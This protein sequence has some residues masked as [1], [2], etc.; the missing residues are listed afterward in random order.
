M[1]NSTATTPAASALS[2]ELADSMS[3]TRAMA[4]VEG[5]ATEPTPDPILQIAFGFM[6]SKVL[7]A[8]LE[9]DVFTQLA[10]G[11]LSYELLAQRTGLHHRA[12]R[13][14]LDTLVAMKLLDRTEGVYSLSLL[15]ARYLDRT[16]PG[17]IGGLLEM[18]DARLYGFWHRLPEALRTGHPQNEIRDGESSFQALY[19]DA[20]RLE[21]F[22][23]AMTGLSLAPAR[24]IAAQFPWNRYRTVLDVGCAEGG[25]L[26]EVAARH[27]HIRG[28][29]YDLPVV[30]P[31]FQ[32]YVHSRRVADRVHFRPGDFFADPGLPSAD[33]IVMGHIL[34][35]WNLGEKRALLEKA[36][37]ALPKGGALIVYESLIDDDR[38]E[39][40]AG[41]LMSLNM[42]IETQ[43]GFDFTGRDCMGWMAEA[44]F[45]ETRVEA[46]A[47]GKG[48]VIGVK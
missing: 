40:V 39:N 36:Y 17:F 12:G 22:L 43:G 44:G 5:N 21:C 34:H 18:A 24:S 42:L 35:D 11:P 37:R 27:E 20:E 19:S 38:R 8:A 16:Q 45:A 14:F 26:A 28:Y 46:L 2:G 15:A 1:M 3:A 6:A 25:L 33:V 48:M 31:I 7:F 23:K 47:G 13:D 30:Q 29:G 41:L 10:A 4:Q 32:R 9:L